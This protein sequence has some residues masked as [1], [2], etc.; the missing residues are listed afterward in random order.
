MLAVF[1]SA[2]EALDI[3]QQA[4]VLEAGSQ[5][6]AFLNTN[7]VRKATK[8]QMKYSGKSMVLRF[9]YDRYLISEGAGSTCG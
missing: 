4:A 8:E 5:L 6:W 2:R 7:L 3:G 1:H 9:P